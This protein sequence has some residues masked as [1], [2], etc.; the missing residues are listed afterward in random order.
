MA[1]SWPAALISALWLLWALYWLVSA[2][3]LKAARQRESLIS[4]LAFLVVMLL[5]AT[6][7]LSGHHRLRWLQ[8]QWI[9]GGWTRYWI[10]VALVV[11]G[12][13]F[14]VWARRVLGGNWSGT[15]SVKVDHELVQ[16]GPYRRI[17]HPIYTGLLLAVFGSGLAAGRLYGV[18]AFLLVALALWWRQRVEERWMAAEFGERY[19][20]Y[21]RSS[22]ALVPFVF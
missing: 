15:V 21:R 16:T 4:R 7:L 9:S 22:W 14:S 12:L 5:A 3:S 18:A 19:E 8:A 2:R 6:L 20:R 13:S 1:R 10:A 17:R 11:A